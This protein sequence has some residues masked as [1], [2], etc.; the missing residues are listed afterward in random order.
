M[1]DSKR[2]S[3]ELLLAKI[4]KI[5]SVLSICNDKLTCTSN[6]VSGMLLGEVKYI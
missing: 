2:F 4:C 1:Y 5:Y 3:A 6:V